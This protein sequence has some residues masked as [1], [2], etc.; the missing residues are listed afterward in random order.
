MDTCHEKIC[1]K[2]VINYLQKVAYL[3]RS[4]GQVTE[5]ETQTEMVDVSEVGLA[6]DQKTGTEKQTPNA[7]GNECLAGATVHRARSER[8]AGTTA[9]ETLTMG[10]TGLHKTS[11][12]WERSTT[13][14]SAVLCGSAVSC[15][16]KAS[17]Q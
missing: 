3:L 14:R 12:L 4:S 13:A 8:T 17:G 1:D 5:V 9:A 11:P 2:L 6:P 10:E 7:E 16:W 15:S